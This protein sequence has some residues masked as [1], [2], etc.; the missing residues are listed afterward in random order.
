MEDFKKLGVD[1]LRK[2]AR[3][4]LGKASGRLRTRA[5]LLEALG[6][7][8]RPDVERASPVRARVPARVKPPSP[9]KRAAAGEPAPAAKSR[10]QRAPT[11]A[12]AAVSTE[13]A[14]AARSPAPERKPSIRGKSV[15]AAA[16]AT[17]QKAPAKPAPKK[18]RAKAPRSVEAEPPSAPVAVPGTGNGHHP[19]EGPNG[20]GVPS[21]GPALSRPEVSSVTLGAQLA[22]LE[23]SRPPAAS[24][25]LR[26]AGAP[27]RAGTPPDGGPK[28]GAREDARTPRPSPS[29]PAAPE[30]PLESGFF[31]DRGAP[32]PPRSPV[33]APEVPEPP[34]VILP[35]ADVGTEAPVLL[36]R[37]P[38]TLFVFWDFR[39]ELERGAALGLVEPRLLLRLFHGERPDRSVELPLGA[40][41]TYVEGL[42]AGEAYS[43]EVML[44]GRDGWTRPMGRRS[45]ARRLPPDGPSERLEVRTLR[46]PWSEPLS[47][48]GQPS[49]AVEVPASEA[50]DSPRRV[51]LPTSPGARRGPGGPLRSGNH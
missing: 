30:R 29:L 31:E 48:A 5:E 34:P 28:P 20:S 24:R 49:E 37:D 14:G 13:R 25:P 26:A 44:L 22:A 18:S 3:E 2:L 32:R 41:S 7:A 36:V 21:A 40:R 27:P 16:R 11:R 42:S 50:L 12:K 33:P 51:P 38:T 43:A 39:R 23:R 45:N 46:M 17:P 1:A 15:V 8:P 6:K 35:P 9:A 10:A 47:Q 19:P 4:R